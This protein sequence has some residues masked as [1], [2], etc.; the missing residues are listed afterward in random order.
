MNSGE[1]IVVIGRSRKSFYCP[2][3]FTIHYPLI[4]H[5]S[6]LIHNFLR[7]STASSQA[8]VGF[9]LASAA[10]FPQ[11]TLQSERG[12]LGSAESVRR[13][14]WLLEG[15]SPGEIRFT[16]S[17]LVPGRC[18]LLRNPSF[19]GRMEAPNCQALGRKPQDERRDMRRSRALHVGGGSPAHAETAAQDIRDYGAARVAGPG[20][21]FPQPDLHVGAPL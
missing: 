14:R 2:L 15:E 12:Y 8:K 10:V 21:I 19:Q 11:G 1:W 3:L 6:I 5:F 20:R 18:G 13:C 16:S 7:P 4:P 9:A 17:E